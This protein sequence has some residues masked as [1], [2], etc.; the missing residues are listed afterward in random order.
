MDRLHAMNAFVTVAELRGFAP[1]ARKLKLSPS[2]VTRLVA[3]LEDHLSAR[4]LHRTTRSV[5]LTDA[6]AR[7]LERAR[8]I[9]SDVGEAEALTQADRTEPSGRFVVTA[10]QVFGRIH[11]APLMCEFL[12]QH[13]KVIGELT[14]GD[15]AINLVEEGVDAAIRIGTLPDSSVIARSVGATRRVVVAAPRY[16]KRAPPLRRP[17]DLAKHPLIQFTGIGA[18]PHWTFVRRGEPMTIALEPRFVTNSA[19]AALAHAELGGGLAM[20]LGYQVLAA[21]KAKR[22]VVVLEDFEPA[23]LPIHVLYPSSRL[24]TSKVRAFIELLTRTRDW[25]FT[26]F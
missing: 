7:Y 26:D 25:R 8:R 9:L 24:L 14:L 6:G 4:L 23:P 5:K 18:T 1:A 17:D 22:L 3:A 10:P 19:D 20:A 2:V 11:V 15:R 16:L 12:A 13:P 21:V